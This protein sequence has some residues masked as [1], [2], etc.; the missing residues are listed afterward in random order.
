MSTSES[1][2]NTATARSWI[3]SGDPG[4]SLRVRLNNLG[5]IRMVVGS[6]SGVMWGSLAFMT[7]LL[8]WIWADVLLDLSPELRLTG[9]LAAF[10]AFLF[11]VVRI[12]RRTKADAGN[13]KLAAALDMAQNSGGEIRSG[14][15]LSGEDRLGI[16]PNSP[17]LSGELADIAV[18]KAAVLAQTAQ[19]QD[20]APITPALKPFAAV[21][22]TIFVLAI[23]ILIGPRMAWTQ[24][25]RFF[26]PYGDHPAYSQYNFEVQQD[27][28]KVIYG[29]E[30]NISVRV[31]G[32][33]VDQVELVMVP[34]ADERKTA[35][36]FTEPLNV[37]PM[38]SDSE[39][40]WHS[41]IAS[42][43]ESFDY[44][45]RVRRARSEIFPV[46]VVT[47]PE[48]R[49]V[50]LEI[51]A[52]LY[53]GLPVYRGPIPVTSIEGPNG[54]ERRPGIKGLPGTEVAINASSNRPL[55]G[56]SLRYISDGD[57]QVIQLTATNDPY[58]VTGTFRISETGRID[59]TIIDEANQPSAQ[60]TSIPV[61]KLID[62]SP[63]VR[64]TQPK[65]TSFATPTAKL[66]I[67]VSGEDDFGI[68]RCQLFRSLNNSRFLPTD[69]ELSER[70]PARVQTGTV[71]PLAEYALQPGDEIR[72]F[73]RVEDNDPHGPD[74]PFGKGSESEI[75]S[76][77]IISQ[78]DFDRVQQQKDGM[79]MMQNRY[80]QAQRRLENLAE[81]VSE[82]LEQLKQADPDS[83]LSA[84]LREQ[85]LK[86]GAQ[87]KSESEA[88]E[89]LSEQPLP[90]ELDR[91]LAPQL[92]EM[93]ERLR[94]M[95]EQTS[96]TAGNPATN[97]QQATEQMQQQLDNLKNEQQRHQQEAMNPL[98][99]LE[100]VLPLKQA[101]QEFTQL[102]QRQRQL[103]DRL[104][105]LNVVNQPDDPATRARMRELEEEQ[106]RAREQLN[107]LMSRI[108][109]HADSLPE[110][111]SLDELRESAREFAS[112][113]RESQAD[114][115]MA[116]A[117]GALA[118]SDG[119]Q[120]HERAD[121]AAQKLE[122]LLSQCQGMGQQCENSMPK[123]SPGLG[124]CMSDTLQQLAPGE[125][126]GMKP[127][128]GM[129]QG[130]GSGYSTQMSTMKNVGMYG[131][132][133]QFD[134]ANTSM[135]ESESDNVGGVFSDPF[136]ENRG[137]SDTGFTTR[138]TNSAFGGAEWGVPIQYRRQAG[139]YLQG[140]VEELD[141]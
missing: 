89:K 61:R 84:E 3:G 62:Q 75:V 52:P 109:E 30:L 95:S 7:T 67:A 137:N 11:L 125:Q 110:N 31:D 15:D 57:T 6:I 93:A 81:K 45:L 132:R 68:R 104:N 29:E 47:V 88:I 124:K 1:H 50:N 74:A 83:N 26:N 72:L 91:E 101:E 43:T 103:A 54:V 14:L 108:E 123:F 128:T 78:E 90:L 111:T 79:K 107:D 21:G 131:G 127:G 2:L 116:R 114:I 56:G 51:T 32:P 136:A 16:A 17:Q 4:E 139:R 85:M 46:P 80:Q 106:H 38:F 92:K 105:A 59:L 140:L 39:G 135:G 60:A 76:V 87:M 115:D 18:R 22:T 69:L 70:S 82:L 36:E 41:S 102:V 66:P 28:E 23:G 12:V 55:S 99:H 133:P 118:D 71:L 112:A 63:M 65:A 48:I 64:L 98:D 20:V 27:R 8:A 117:E 53:T 126:A 19:D 49:N 58:R 94:Q 35:I 130:A 138:Q 122:Q 121:Q 33:D 113:V 86:I 37:L 42:I 9:W 24:T 96:Q 25:K 100:K 13:D 119:E 120:G 34:P 97:G 73:A 5:Q 134:P 141:N 129:G 44:Y 77:R 10:A 40:Q